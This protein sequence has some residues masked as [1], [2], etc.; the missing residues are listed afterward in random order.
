MDGLTTRPIAGLIPLAKSWLSPPK[1]QVDGSG[2]QNE[3]YDPT[4]RAYVVVRKGS[5]GAGRLRLTLQASK[6]SPLFD[7]AIVIRN[8]G[9]GAARLEIDGKSVAWDKDYRMGYIHRSQQDDIVIWMQRQSSDI[10]H[11][12]I[13]PATR[14]S[15]NARE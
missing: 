11:V 14:R 5:A 8:W 4:Q 13:I 12:G 2:F 1:L 7:P 3:G 6:A 10:L 15:S 9:T